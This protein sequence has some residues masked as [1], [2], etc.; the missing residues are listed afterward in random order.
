MSINVKD[1]VIKHVPSRFKVLLW[2]YFRGGE[3]KVTNTVS[4]LKG[5]AQFQP[6]LWTFS[7]TIENESLTFELYQE[8]GGLYKLLGKCHIA[9]GKFQKS[10]VLK[11][12]GNKFLNEKKKEIKI[13]LDF[14]LEYELPYDIMSIQHA[15]SHAVLFAGNLDENDESSDDLKIALPIPEIDIVED[16]KVHI[17]IHQGK[18]LFGKDCRP[19]VRL[20]IL[21]EKSS[22][23]VSDSANPVWEEEFMF[24]FKVIRAKLLDSV[25]HIK[26]ITSKNFKKEKI[27]SAKFDLWTVYNETNHCIQKKWAVLQEVNSEEIKGYILVSISIYQ[28]EEP[29]QLALNDEIDLESNLLLPIGYIAPRDVYSYSITVYKAESVAA[30]KHSIIT[31]KEKVNISHPFIKIDFGGESESTKHVKKSVDPVFNQVIE[32][33]DY[34]PPMYKRIKISLNCKQG[35]LESD[36]VLAT[37]FID[38]SDISYYGEDIDWIYADYG[39]VTLDVVYPPTFG[40]CW[41]NL[42]GSTTDFER[43]EYMNQGFSKGNSYRGRVLIE[44]QSNR[45]ENLNSS[46]MKICKN[47]ESYVE[48][49]LKRENFLLFATFYE[50]SMLEEKHKGKEICFEVSIGSCG[51]HDLN[52]SSINTKITIGNNDGSK[53]SYNLGLEPIEDRWPFTEPVKATLASSKN[54]C[55]LDFGTSKPNVFLEFN[56]ADDSFRL[57]LII[58]LKKIYNKIDNCLS[59]VDKT[60]TTAVNVSTAAITQAFVTFSKQVHDVLLYY[61]ALLNS[62][63][64]NK[65]DEFLA[66]RRMQTLEQLKKLFGDLRV[67]EATIAQKI[68]VLKIIKMQLGTIVNDPQQS[69]PDIFIWMIADKKRIAYTRVKAES[70]LNSQD[71]FF[72]APY[73]GKLQS[74]FLQFY[75]F[76]KQERNQRFIQGKIE[77]RIWLGCSTN[78]PVN[79]LPSDDSFELPIDRSTPY[80]RHLEYKSDQKYILHAHIFQGRTV[81]GSDE[82]G[83][84]DPFARVM[85]GNNMEETWAVPK[86]RMPLWDQSFVF[87]KVTLYGTNSN[88]S[89]PVVLITLFD[90]DSNGEEFIGQAIASPRL[91]TNDYVPAKLQLIPLY[92]GKQSVGDI[93]ASF[94]LFPVDYDNLPELPSP[95]SRNQAYTKEPV[96]CVPVPR[97][98]RPVLVSYKVELLFWGLRDLEKNSG[99]FGKRVQRPQVFADFSYNAML[100]NGKSVNKLESTI[101]RNAIRNPNFEN[102]ILIFDMDLPEN[103]AWMPDCTFMVVDHSQFTNNKKIQFFATHTTHTIDRFIFNAEEFKTTYFEGSAPGSKISLS[104]MP[105]KKV[106]KETVINIEPVDNEEVVDWWTRFYASEKSQ[107][108]DE[109]NDLINITIYNHELEKEFNDFHDLFTTFPLVRGKQDAFKNE[110]DPR[111][112]KGKFKGAIRLW[113]NEDLIKYKRQLKANEGTFSYLP[114]KAPVKVCVRIYCI[115]ALGL[116]AKDIISGKSDP[117]IIVQFGKSKS[118]NPSKHVANNLNP[119]FGEVHEVEGTIPFDTTLTVQVY[120]FDRGAIRNELIGQTQIDIE[121]RYFTKYRAKCGLPQEYKKQGVAK[122]RDIQ[123]PTEI[124]SELALRCKIDVDYK[125]SD[126]DQEEIAFAALKKFQRTDFKFVP[127]HVE[128]RNLTHPNH[129]EVSQGKLLMWADIFP[130]GNL[131]PPVDIAKPKPVK[132]EIRIIIWNCSNVPCIDKSILL[133]NMPTSD[134]YV[135]GWLSGMPGKSQKTDIHYRSTDGSGMFNWRFIFQFDYYQAKRMFIF[136]KKLSPLSIDETEFY[137]PAELI[138]ECREADLIGSRK[139]GRLNIDLLKL[140]P[141]Y[142]KSSG[143]TLEDWEERLKNK[144]E[145]K[146][147]LFKYRNFKGW[148][149]FMVPDEIDPKK[150]VE[151][152]RVE[153][154]IE[155]VTEDEAK[156]RPVGIR[157]EEPQALPKPDRPEE[158]LGLFMNPFKM[159]R[160][161]WKSYKWFIFKVLL[162][163]LLL[164]LIA[165]FIYAFPG[166]LAKKTIGI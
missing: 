52:Q 133:G 142:I 135:K 137:F 42:Y 38:L 66:K 165:L 150:N 158:S 80:P 115:M 145:K 81:F 72:C 120:D 44:I 5:I 121:N 47:V 107:I 99:I 88:M 159:A 75:K 54:S 28:T 100:P 46:D 16:W 155:L 97:A 21:D 103:T 153:I 129:P 15:G 127:E 123:S 12:Y 67:Q 78:K 148:L 122:W 13:E 23:N 96:M 74:L 154:E 162:L 102:P 143:W 35:G 11:F 140:P 128:T 59:I 89:L 95:V 18:E 9:F 50:A 114:P 31:A 32:F 77:I 64:L 19:Y 161:L 56:K 36:E 131:P 10:I 134:I 45:L 7:K 160:L 51:I 24:S 62:N 151:Q 149:P 39:I 138:L 156:D 3:Q 139:F 57:H 144:K 152:G 68:E 108:T 164:L 105:K 17:R 110:W 93:L 91:I 118:G 73:S 90:K 87:D 113:R 30:A 132:Y 111:R 61:Q 27:G 126:S 43:H 70:V 124:I 98:I 60:A 104:Y 82:N 141:Y 76:D 117:Y 130:A 147:S 106:T 101:C 6:Q 8:K 136:K 2:I 85:F 1:I 48:E 69:F 71:L 37:H 26:A 79:Y 40:P 58:V 119:E 83:L 33:R 41:I 84:S 63:T 29:V 25:L 157:R 109:E 116:T 20:R 53:N 22:T 125:D 55:F 86:T 14:E 92:L 49:K 4:S 112:I 34:F 146:M 163:L 166:Y 94:E 65:S